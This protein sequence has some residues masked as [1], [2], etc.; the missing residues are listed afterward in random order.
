M[1]WLV[2]ALTAVVLF[3]ALN[4]LQRK[5]SIES[6]DP[7]ATAVL[8]NLIAGLI[9]ICIFIFNG[10]LRTFRLPTQP[11]GWLF[12]ILAIVCYGFFERGR[13][14]AA[15]LLDVAIF[16]TIL[17]ISLVIS[18]VGS[19][20][21]YHEPLTLSKLCG[22]SLILIAL[23]ITAYQPKDPT[24]KKISP[25]GLLIATGISILLGLAWLMDK[26][27]AIYFS[28]TTY[29]AFVWTLPVF[30][31]LFPTIPKATYA[32]EL[33]TAWWK[34][35]LIAGINVVAYLFQLHSIVLAGETRTM[36]V[37][38]TSI[39]L[40]TVA[41]IFILKEKDHL[42]KKFVCGILAVIGVI[43]LMM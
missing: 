24:K 11:M 17:T 2:Y 27:N 29:T 1:L 35:T 33:K 28:P 31:I 22:V 3:T 30:C 20:L 21:I 12:F 40:S 19:V 43:F 23:L 5:I 32:K 10:S 7:R 15:K 6:K 25:L 42:L 9:A 37:I 34:I 38:Q 18:F 41:A 8:F 4:I 13:F 16:D 39:L 26:A 36:P 14:F